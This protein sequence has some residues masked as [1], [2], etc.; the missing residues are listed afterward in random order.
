MLTG[1]NV[2][3]DLLHVPFLGCPGFAA[4]HHTV[5]DL[6]AQRCRLTVAASADVRSILDRIG[7]GA[8]VPC[9]G[10]VANAVHAA[11]SPQTSAGSEDPTFTILD[12]SGQRT[13]LAESTPWVPVV[14]EGR[15]LPDDSAVS[16]HCVCRRMV[17]GPVTVA[18]GTAGGGQPTLRQPKGPARCVATGARDHQGGDG[19]G[20]DGVD[21][22]EPD[23]GLRIAVVRHS[24]GPAGV[25]T[26]DFGMDNVA[27]LRK[28]VAYLEIAAPAPLRPDLVDRTSLVARR[29]LWL[30]T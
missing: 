28:L 17:I 1:H 13:A 14:P 2:V 12:R 5:T 29:R 19:S 25:I 15:A 26:A 22:A 8:A 4:L 30:G 16:M 21:S 10:T 24:S 6:S 9:F 3:V 18:G 11:R 23:G 20:S 27:F 7:I